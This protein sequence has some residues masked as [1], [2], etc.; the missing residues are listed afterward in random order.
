MRV[1]GVSQMGQDVKSVSPTVAFGAIA[2]RC[3]TPSIGASCNLM[4]PSR[5]ATIDSWGMC[6]KWDRP[7][8]RLTPWAKCKSRANNR[9]CQVRKAV[10]IWPGCERCGPSR[11]VTKFRTAARASQQVMVTSRLPSLMTPIAPC[12]ED[13]AIWPDHQPTARQPGSGD[14]EFPTQGHFRLCPGPFRSAA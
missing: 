7:T 10:I 11:Y 3:L 8:K 14:D 4:R 12:A 13:S 9:N 5:R 2:W 1:L 6:G